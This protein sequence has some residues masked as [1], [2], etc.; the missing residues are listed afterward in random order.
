[1]VKPQ[2]ALSYNKTNGTPN[3]VSWQLNRSWLGDT[4]RQNN[5]RPDPALPTDW[6]HVKPSDYTNSGYD[7]GHM[8]PSEDRG[9]TVADNSAT[10]LMTNIIPQAPDLNRGPWAYLE[11]YC[12]DLVTKQGKELYVISGGYGTQGNLANGKVTIPAK[13]WKVIVVLDSAGLGVKGVTTSTRVIAVMIPNSDE[14]RKANWKSYRTT[15]RQ[16]ESST[17]YNLLSNVPASVQNVI[18]T[19]ADNNE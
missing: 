17:G 2:Y 18:E 9:K 8:T 1:M 4:P 19:K 15:V 3:W 5:F 12:R 10:F 6:Y 16:I 7:R 14:I 13:T 11:D